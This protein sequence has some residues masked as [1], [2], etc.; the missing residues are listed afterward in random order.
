MHIAYPDFL[1]GENA[2]RPRVRDGEEGIHRL[3]IQ[4]VE[5]DMEAVPFSHHCRYNIQ[6]IAL[7]F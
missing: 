1:K 3:V 4:G 6:L 2:V 5:G 7:P